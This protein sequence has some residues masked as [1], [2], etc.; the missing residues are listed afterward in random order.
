MIVLLALVLNRKGVRFENS[1][2]FTLSQ[3][4]TGEWSPV[5][6]NHKLSY[7][8]FLNRRSMS[9]NSILKKFALIA[10]GAMMLPAFA[11]ADIKMGII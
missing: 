3:C 6:F 10:A 11:V 7:F 8:F 1:F 2:K 4:K 9:K 5:A